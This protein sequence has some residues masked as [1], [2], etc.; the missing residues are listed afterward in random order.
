M[1]AWRK[2]GTLPTLQSWCEKMKRPTLCDRV[3]SNAKGR[4]SGDLRPVSHRR[5]KQTVMAPLVRFSVSF[6]LCAAIAF[7]GYLLAGAS[8][9]LPAE[10]RCARCARFG[11]TTAVKPGM[12]CPLSYRGH[13]CHSRVGKTA[14]H[15]TLCPDGC[16]RHDGQG[17]EI[18]SP[19][20][21]L[22]PPPVTLPVWI[23]LGPTP[24]AV[25]PF[26]SAPPFFPPDHPPTLRARR[27][28]SSFCVTRFNAEA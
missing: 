17:S 19:A 5:R 2:A 8:L 9:A 24:Q 7:L 6:R 13:D 20:K 10:L 15:I 21:F 14:G 12:S 3:S 1:E 25:P 4:R 16:L 23:L 28:F 22:S 11:T 27:G 26:L 18:P